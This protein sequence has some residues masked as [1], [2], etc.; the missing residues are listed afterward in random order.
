MNTPTRMEL[1]RRV[2][3]SEAIVAADGLADSAGKTV[4]IVH[5][6]DHS[7]CHER[8]LKMQNWQELQSTVLNLDDVF[9]GGEGSNPDLQ[10]G[11]VVFVSTAALVYVVGNVAKPQSL[12]LKRYN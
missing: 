1:H 7:G 2:R 12:V 6:A 5:G 11:D 8:V 4:Q 10:D 3:L 9:R